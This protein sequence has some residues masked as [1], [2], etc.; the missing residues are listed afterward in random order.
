MFINNLNPTLIHLGP[1]EIRW[2]G[3][4]YVFGFFLA[5]YWLNFLR[6]KGKLSLSSEEITELVFYLMLGVLIG[7]RLFLLFWMP[8][9]YLLKP[10]NLLLIWQGGMSFHGGL[11]GVII[12]G[13]IY[14]R[15][16]K[17]KFW[18]LADILSVPA[19]LA[20]ALGRAANFVNGELVGRQWSGSW[21]VVTPRYDQIC[22]HP[23]MIY[24][25]FQ[26]I[27]VFSWLVFLS[28]KNKSKTQAA[29][30][31]D[32]TF[33]SFKE[34]FIFW[35]FVFWEGIGRI[36]VDFYRED[37]LYG[38]FSLGQW[39]SL[40]MVAGALIMFIKKY[41]EDWKKILSKKLKRSLHN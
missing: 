29:T 17:I 33:T 32:F 12:A 25:F 34:G 15:K 21:C 37:T 38:G 19:M 4:V 7:A 24:S 11:A 18:A 39:F 28:L 22:R 40:V 26:R 1:L 27:V 13:W 35:N 31:Q 20:L 9:V 23:N 30:V 8:E 5:I 41:K 3:L 36:M 10:W 16:K 6:K 14:C 2:Y